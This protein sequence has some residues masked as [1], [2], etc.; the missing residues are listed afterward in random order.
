MVR[1]CS[2]LSTNSSITINLL[3]WYIVALN[4]MSV[5]LMKYILILAKFISIVEFQDGGII[6][7]IVHYDNLNHSFQ[8]NRFMP[9][10]INH[11]VL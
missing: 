11:S 4:K 8:L 2:F 7:Y 3:F 5:S 9:G 6:N 10:Q 1:L